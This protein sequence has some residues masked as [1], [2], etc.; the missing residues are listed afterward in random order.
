MCFVNRY[1]ARNV[2]KLTSSISEIAYR[3]DIEGYF[4]VRQL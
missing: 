3:Y 4:I 2:F 1:P